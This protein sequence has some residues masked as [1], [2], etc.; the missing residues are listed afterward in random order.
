[1]WAQIRSRHRQTL[2]RIKIGNDDIEADLK[3]L[4][5]D[6]SPEH[7]SD[8]QKERSQILARIAAIGAQKTKKQ[9]GSKFEPQTQWCSDVQTEAIV[10][11]PESKV[12]VKTRPDQP[13]QQPDL[14]L[15]DLDIHSDI[16]DPPQ[17]KVAVSKR[18]LEI[19]QS[20]Y[21]KSN[22]EE[23][24]KSVDWASFVHAMAEVGFIAR[25]THGSEYS[26]EPTPTCKWYG[27]GKIVF[28]KPHPEPKYEAWK[29]L[30][31]GKRMGKWFDWNANTFE[32]QEAM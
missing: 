13:V 20:L 10:S 26:F 15:K 19:L 31:I 17:V 28:H 14:D 2:E 12:K 25:Q 4:S 5:A 6:I 32:L 29:L 11:G 1:L 9:T 21:P 18:S 22:F 30:G 8:V 7:I 23:R 16:K 3:V 24:T 27:R